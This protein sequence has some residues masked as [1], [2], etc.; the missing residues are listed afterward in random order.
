MPGLSVNVKDLRDAEPTEVTYKFKGGIA[1]FVDHLA[2]DEAVTSIIRLVGSGNFVENVPVLDDE[3]H[4]VPREIERE[5]HVDIAL[6][7]GTGYE[8]ELKSFVNVVAT[9]KG[10][11]HVAGFERAITKVINDQLK[12]QKILKP[13]EE[14]VLKDDV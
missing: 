6:R 4:M 5:M 12:S 7:W 3:G 11:T 1:E 8:T 13:S 9:P 14:N 2:S 10:G